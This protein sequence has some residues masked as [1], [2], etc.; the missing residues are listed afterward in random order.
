MEEQRSRT[1][2][3]AALRWQRRELAGMFHE[4][5]GNVDEKKKK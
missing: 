2:K 1:V 5:R 3:Q 4:W